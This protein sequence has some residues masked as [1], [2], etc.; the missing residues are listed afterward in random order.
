MKS[1]VKLSVII[2]LA[3]AALISCGEDY[4]E[5]FAEA[6]LEEVN[7]ARTDPAGYA[8]ARLKSYYNNNNDNGAYNDIKSRSAVSALTLNDDLC[9][10]ADKYAEYLA[11]N[12]EF[13]HT[14]DGTPQERVEEEGYNNYSGEN[15]ACGTSADRNADDSP[16][17]AAQVFVEQLIIDEGV[18]SLGHRE[19]IMSSTHKAFGAGFHHD[20]SAQYKN[21]CVQNFGSK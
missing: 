7:Y 8:E 19:N 21:Y 17:T 2:L 11:V 13:S 16:A 3:T 6:M 18:P 10:A 1:F 12:N 4:D 5:E 15:L 20:D 14:A 9:T